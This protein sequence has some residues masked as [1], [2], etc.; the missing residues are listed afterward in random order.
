MKYVSI[1]YSKNYDIIKYL[2]SD[3]EMGFENGE[4]I[5]KVSK[6]RTLGVCIIQHT[7]YMFLNILIDEFDPNNQF[8]QIPAMLYDKVL[9][10][11]QRS[12]KIK[13]ILEWNI[14]P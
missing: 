11:E 2:F 5:E 13:K 8:I 14:Y 3:V 10:L 4:F 7:N 6:H 1:V 12:K 9:V